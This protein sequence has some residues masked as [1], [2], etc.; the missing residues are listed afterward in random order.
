M[1]KFGANKFKLGLAD[2][3]YFP[4][5][6]TSAG[7]F[8]PG[9][10]VAV[11]GD[12]QFVC[13][14][15]GDYSGGAGAGTPFADANAQFWP[16]PLRDIPIAGNSSGGSQMVRDAVNTGFQVKA[17]NSMADPDVTVNGT[18]NQRNGDNVITSAAAGAVGL[19]GNPVVMWKTPGVSSYSFKPR[20][21]RG[22]VLAVNVVLQADS[23]AF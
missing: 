14:R 6:S 22:T 13:E 15:R 23:N 10:Q 9:S 7:G 1:G 12:I 17:D 11:P 18:L 16:N 3:N 2:V 19:S 4:P 20:E 5:M 21:S 8:D